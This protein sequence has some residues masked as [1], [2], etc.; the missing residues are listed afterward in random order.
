[1]ELSLLRKSNPLFCPSYRPPSLSRPRIVA[2]SSYS[3]PLACSPMISNHPFLPPPSHS[4]N[5]NISSLSHHVTQCL[6]PPTPPSFSPLLSIPRHMYAQFF[7]PSVH[8]AQY[9]SIL[10]DFLVA[11]SSPISYFLLNINTHSLISIIFSPPHTLP[12]FALSHFFQSR[13]NRLRNFP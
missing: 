4:N 10:T 8:N 12:P 3:S 13:A 9:I 2:L 6:H 1:M 7:K 11:Y 5:N